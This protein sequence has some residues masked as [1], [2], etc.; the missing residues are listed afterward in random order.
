MQWR[1]A[2][3]MRPQPEI[4]MIARPT[5]I[6][7]Q[8]ASSTGLPAAESPLQRQIILWQRELV[9]RAEARHKAASEPVALQVETKARLDLGE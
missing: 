2:E 4:D 8:D 5:D 3:A 7:R 9:R 1:K 6:T